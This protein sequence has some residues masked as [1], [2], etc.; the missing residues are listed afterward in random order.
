M[1]AKCPA[2]LVLL[3]LSV[4]L[5]AFDSPPPEV[6]PPDD[7]EFTVG[8]GTLCPGGAH[9]AT[10]VITPRGL[11]V[12][13]ETVLGC[14]KMTLRNARGTSYSPKYALTGVN[15]AHG[16]ALITGGFTSR[17][18]FSEGEPVY[19][20]TAGLTPSPGAEPVQIVSHPSGSRRAYVRSADNFSLR[21]EAWSAGGTPEKVARNLD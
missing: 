7:L 4:L 16:L 8:V 10:G 5:A 2:A 3:V 18:A 13:L 15:P 9:D 21:H 1:T 6:T 11:V 19:I 20:D 14:S 12:P 17:L